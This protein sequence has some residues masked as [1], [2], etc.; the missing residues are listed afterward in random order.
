[1]IYA[2]ENTYEG[3][4]NKKA[5]HGYGKYTWKDGTSY[6]GEYLWDEKHGKGTVITNDRKEYRNKSFVNGEMESVVSSLV[7]HDN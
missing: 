6:E 3:Q 5:K 2:N 4:L 7:R 1:M